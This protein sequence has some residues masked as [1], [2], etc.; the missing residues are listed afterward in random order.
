M[1]SGELGHHG[2]HVEVTARD[3]DLDLALDLV[4]KDIQLTSIHVLVEF[5]LVCIYKTELDN[6]FHV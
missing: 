4:V 2:G 3:Q 5:A 6:Y 1:V